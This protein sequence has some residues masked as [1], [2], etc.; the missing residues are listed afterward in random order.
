M[1]DMLRA[2]GRPKEHPHLVVSMWA[3]ILRRVP[4]IAH[5]KEPKYLPLLPEKDRV[6]GPERFAAAVEISLDAGETLP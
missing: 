5:Q 2:D 3:H 4:G 6:L 1:P